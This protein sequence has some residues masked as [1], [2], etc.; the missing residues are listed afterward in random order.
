M[1]YAKSPHP[2][3]DCGKPVKCRTKTRCS[4]CEK[5]KIKS[6]N[7]EVYKARMARKRKK[8]RESGNCIRCGSPDRT[9]K[10]YCSWCLAKLRQEM[11][12]ERAKL[13]K[14]IITHYGGKCA[15]CGQSIKEFLSIDHIN[16][17]GNAH[18]R[19]IK[20]SGI[21]LYRWLRKNNY[22]EGFRVLCMNCNWAIGIYGEE[23]VLDLLSR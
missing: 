2:C 20:A 18:R 14:E 6:E 17:G 22:P 4:V 21:N 11:A 5:R 8:K 13:R 19:E 9:S 16:G 7:P 15:C 3:P 23:H 1:P 12:S 10:L